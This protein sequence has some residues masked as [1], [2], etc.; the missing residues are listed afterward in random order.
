[1]S[2]FGV[3]NSYSWKISK[4]IFL[5]KIQSPVSLGGDFGVMVLSV[6]ICGLVSWTLRIS[7]VVFSLDLDFG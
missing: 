4:A 1:M 3:S 2:I 7:M 5:F 6:V